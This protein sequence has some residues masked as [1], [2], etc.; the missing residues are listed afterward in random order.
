MGT[1]DTTQ[2]HWSQRRALDAIGRQGHARLDAELWDALS[3]DCAPP[4][5]S[6]LLRPASARRQPGADAR[7]DTFEEN[8]TMEENLDMHRGT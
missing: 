5:G 7:R 6:F 4:A 3:R 2:V 1:T 8:T